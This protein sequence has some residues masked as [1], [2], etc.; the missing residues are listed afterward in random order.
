[1][2]IKAIIEGILFVIG[3]EGITIDNLVKIIECTEEEVKENL[4]LL[5]KD[6]ENDD[7]GIRI[8][9]LGNAFKLTTKDIHK[10]Y[11]EKLIMDSKTYNLTNA[12]LEILAIVAYNE[13]ITRMK[14]DEVRGVNSSQTLRKLVAIGF[15]KE[16]GKANVL[17]RPNL[18]KTTNE[19]LDYFGL[20]T[21][22][23]LPTLKEVEEVTDEEKDLYTSSYKDLREKETINS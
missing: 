11:Y 21:K 22:N 20:A 19:F 2:N 6:Y 10:E 7:R 3:D 17:G 14:I 13:P 9:F 23:D 15:I 5:R 4:S 1:M 12:A 18:Y 16:A 8:S